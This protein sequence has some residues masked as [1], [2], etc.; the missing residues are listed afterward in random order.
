MKLSLGIILK[1]LLLFPS[2]A[3][4]A[5]NSGSTTT[6][7][8]V[9]ESPNPPALLLT[10]AFPGQSFTQPVALIQAP[11]DNQRWYLVEKGGLIFTFTADDEQAAVFADLTAQVDASQFESGLLGM[12]FHPDFAANRQVLL[13][14]TAPGPDT[15]TPLVSHISRFQAPTDEL[16]IDMTSEEILLTLDQPFGNHNGGQILFGPDG[17]LYISF[18]DGG[19][20]GDPRG[21]GQ[22]TDTLLGAILRI[23]VDQREEGRNYAIPADNPFA[24]GG[25]APEIYAWGQ[26]N[27]WRSSFDRATGVF[28]SADVGQNAWEE[29]NIIE[30]GGNYGWNFR[31]GAHCFLPPVACP[32]AGLIDPVTEYPNAGGDCSITGGYVYRGTMFPDLA[33]TYIFGDFCSGRIWGLPTDTNGLPVGPHH[34]LLDSPL[35]ISSFAEGNEGEVYVL[36]FAGGSIFRLEQLP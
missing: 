5:C 10:E 33:G 24:T 17:L 32:T 34:L 18:G 12:A 21:H 19:A 14:Y 4:F 3:L 35:Q 20:G 6:S 16:T 29:V 9:G 31:E 7:P 25:G 13:S 28:W 27:P 11:A 2:L 23:D 15:S 30:R 36:D 22:N 1:F 26:R 8:P